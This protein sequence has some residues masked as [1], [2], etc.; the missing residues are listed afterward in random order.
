MLAALEEKANDA[1]VTYLASDA[2]IRDDIAIVAITE[3]TLADLPYR[4]PVDRGFLAD[5]IGQLNAAGVKA[6]GI[7]MLF[8]SATEIEKDDRLKSVMA[9][10]AAPV[11]TAFADA[12]NGLSEDQAKYLRYFVGARLRGVPDIAVDGFDHVAR[13][14]HPARKSAAVILPSFS[15]AL[16]AAV[17]AEAPDGPFRIDY[18][19]GSGAE[20]TPFRVI[21]AEAI[22]LVPREWIDGRIAIVGV[23]LNQRDRVWTPI[24]VADAAGMPGVHVH[25]QV[26][27]QLID[28]RRWPSLGLW[29]EIAVVT[30]MTLAGLLSIIARLSVL[31]KTL[32][33]IV[34]VGGFWVLAFQ[35][36]ATASVF[37]PI[38]APTVGFIV[39]LGFALI[40]AK[41]WLSG[42][43][44]RL[45]SAL[46]VYTRW[47]TAE[48]L[49]EGVATLPSVT[50]RRRKLTA[51]MSS[52][53]V[54][55][56]R[57]MREDDAATVDAVR[58]ARAH[59]ADKVESYSGRVVDSPGD[60]L[61]ADF[62]NAL[63]AVE[64]A[65]A[66]QSEPV[67][68]S[69]TVRIGI[70]LGDVIED[71]GAIY[72][73]PVNRA[74]RMESLA[75]P[76]TVCITDI[77]EGQIRGRVTIDPIPLGPKKVKNFA[78]PVETFILRQCDPMQ[79]G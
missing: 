76:G 37:V 21:P 8:D 44:D 70:D 5:V 43:A 69:I 28:G 42:S 7:D 49:R 77:V 51:V 71:D 17:G 12:D 68:E 3:R 61:L 50:A 30:L 41:S 15:A 74:A 64:C 14:H 26:L 25:A 23:V 40:E 75:E 66:I 57:L 22:E 60:A 11:V 13:W 79:H 16:A 18:Q 27:A 59:I 56:S 9:N 34:A 63:A 53:V 4:T 24:E 6:I 47:E 48:A 2:P 67:A 46:A 10:S 29:G 38:I 39:G 32:L 55:Y 36:Y 62:S 19:K 45:G 73:D 72:G 31:A 1:R 33:A 20:R 58:E 78:Q 52:D 35:A 65:L 54:G